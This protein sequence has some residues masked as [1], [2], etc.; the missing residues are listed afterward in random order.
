MSVQQIGLGMTLQQELKE[1]E[2]RHIGKS[3][4]MMEAPLVV[5]GRAF[6]PSDIQ[7]PK[8]L[9]GKILRSPHPHA[10]IISID[11]SEAE[12]ISGVKAIIIGKDLPDVRFGSAIR[13][14]YILARDVVR[15]VGEPVAVVAATEPSIAEEATRAIKVSYQELPTVYDAELALSNDTPALIHPD[16]ASYS[17]NSSAL[18]YSARITKGIPNLTNHFSV[19]RGDLAKGYAEADFIV[20]NRFSTGFGQHAPLEPHAS[21]A[22]AN[23]DGSVTI[24][25][26]CAIPYRIVQQVSDTLQ[27]PL[28]KVRV[29]Q[30]MVGGSYGAK[31][32]MEVEPLCAALSIKAMCPVKIVL[33]RKE[34]FLTVVRHPFVVYV[35]DGVKKDGTIVARTVKCYLNGGAYSAGS[36]NA[37]ARNCAF[38]ITDSYKI[39]NLSVDTYRAYTNLPPA[40]A[41][42]GFG[43]PQVI[44][45]IEQQTDIIAYKLGI[46]PVEFRLRN[47]LQDG[48]TS[49]L[50]EHVHNLPIKECLTKAAEAI[51]WKEP[52]RSVGD[53]RIAK[54]IAVASKYSQA[55]TTSNASVKLYSDGSL[56]VVVTTVDSGQGIRTAMAAVAAEE[57]QVP[58]EKVQVTFPDTAFTPYD[59]GNISS[60]GTFNVG[61]AVRLACKDLKKQVFRAAAKK[62]EC[63]EDELYL[64]ES[65]IL[66]RKNGKDSLTFRDVF[67]TRMSS[68]PAMVGEEG[69]FVGKGTWMVRT[70]KMDP[71]TSQP[72]D[73]EPGQEVRVCSFYT[74]TAQAAEV[75]VNMRTGE[76]KVMKI[77]TV[78]DAGR[79]INRS[80]V[81]SQINGA[82]IMGLGLAL[83]EEMNFEDGRLLNSGFLDYRLLTT[84]DLPEF[85]AI[86]IESNQRDGPFGAKGIGE[87]G[88]VAVGA[89]L[90]NAVH[91]ATGVRM[92]K[93]PI[94][95][96]SIL[97]GLIEKEEQSLKMIP[98]R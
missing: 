34:E 46:D 54:G 74:P 53:W 78:A 95:P 55:P 17:A 20:E 90:A 11:T 19:R 98:S 50:G 9:H 6:Y 68:V 32:N 79:A 66:S 70:S 65:K 93:A 59:D 67:S 36:G 83:S 72:V 96:K 28:A 89:A 61:N 10:K 64:S 60:R 92:W 58:I 43:T 86:I 4:T 26:G 14:R 8:M 97:D 49:A 69:E 37:V 88:I 18:V 27:I 87:I 57:F 73:L 44:W 80:A 77:V 2:F 31:N 7:L 91:N 85:E 15:Y 16:F 39:A 21:V 71:N 47:L 22:Q 40:G 48:D 25:T 82:A 41:F 51:K 1:S 3:Y 38:G 24:W 12:K 76:I 62:L 84:L 81:E 52:P 75:A 30:P 94:T 56:N 29:I 45:A 35:K 63:S 5:S 13:E 42:R 33:T 23:L